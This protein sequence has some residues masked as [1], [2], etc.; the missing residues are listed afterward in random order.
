[1]KKKLNWD[2][3]FKLIGI[4][5]ISLGFITLNYMVPGR[6]SQYGLCSGDSY[7]FGRL[8]IPLFIIG[9]I[10]ILL[11]DILAEKIKKWK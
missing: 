3:A 10:T 7:P 11:S 9:I 4:F 5:I 8:G 2:F 6:V 1:M